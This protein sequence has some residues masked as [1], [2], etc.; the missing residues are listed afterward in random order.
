MSSSDK[1]RVKAVMRGLRRI[2]HKFIAVMAEFGIAVVAKN[3]HIKLGRI[4]GRG[5]LVVIPAT[6]SD[7]R[8]GANAA[9]LLIRLI[10]M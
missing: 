8:A 3:K 6:S 7:H 9:A 10:E 5:G 2:D 4:D 1:Q